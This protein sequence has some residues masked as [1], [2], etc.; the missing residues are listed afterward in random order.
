[1]GWKH[2]QHVIKEIWRRDREN[3]MLYLLSLREDKI[4]GCSS[5]KIKTCNKCDIDGL[6]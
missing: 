6:T 3:K 2:V 4:R 1:M 5:I